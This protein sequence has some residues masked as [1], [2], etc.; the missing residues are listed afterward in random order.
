MT[1]DRG[2]IEEVKAIK[3]PSSFAKA[4]GDK[5][6]VDL[7]VKFESSRPNESPALAGLDLWHAREDSNLRPTD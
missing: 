5:L 3:N 7:S 6:T 4:S 1:A 2:A